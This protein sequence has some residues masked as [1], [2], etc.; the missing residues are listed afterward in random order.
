MK[1]H[2]L[3]QNDGG[4]TLEVSFIQKYINQ[5]ENTLELYR[6]AGGEMIFP[7]E[8]EVSLMFL[9]KFTMAVGTKPQD[10][11]ISSGPV[12]EH[13]GRAGSPLAGMMIGSKVLF[14]AADRPVL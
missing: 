1:S 9:S 5:N 3:D 14:R 13:G 11:P 2:Q 10:S 7:L 4:L 8:L 6:Y 12:P